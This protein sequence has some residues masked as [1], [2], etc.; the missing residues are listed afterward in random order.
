M[1][2]RAPGILAG[3]VG[4]GLAIG[5]GSGSAAGSDTRAATCRVFLVPGAFG[6][7]SGGAAYFVTGEQ[8]FAEYREFFLKKGCAVKV[9]VFPPDGTIEERALVFRDQLEKF[10]R[11]QG[12]PVWVVAHSQGA[13]DVRFALK[14]L[15]VSGVTAVATIGAPHQGTPLSDWV[16]DQRNR[17][18]VLYWAMRVLADYDLREL[19]FAP[20]L[21]SGFLEKHRGR[22]LAVPGV[23]YGSARAVCKTGCSRLVGWVGRW[24]GVG[25]G[26]G[27]IPG[28]SQK[29]GEDL[30][31]FDLDHLSEIA[32]DPEKRAE[33]LRLLER[34]QAFF[35]AKI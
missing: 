28:E 32:V 26:D 24:V 8:Y 5:A 31:E 2:T 22:F 30:G 7:G 19:R 1:R 29:W 25:E 11:E 4:L 17:G 6:P 35:S 20:E 16:I 9:G 12:S 10:S 34:I 21:S 15:K 3:V 27:L 14:T 33:R 13:L 23:R 18:S